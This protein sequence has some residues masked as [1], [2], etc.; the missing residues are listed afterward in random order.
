M[1]VFL[2]ILGLLCC[3]T[4][5]GGHSGSEDIVN[6]L[7]FAAPS[8]LYEHGLGVRL[9]RRQLSVSPDGSTDDVST[10]H[11]HG[12]RL[13][14][15]VTDAVSAT[16]INVERRRYHSV[17]PTAGR[18]SRLR[19]ATLQQACP[20]RRPIYPSPSPPVMS[21][22]P[23]ST[24]SLRPPPAPADV[25]QDNLVF[26]HVGEM[27]FI[28]AL[29]AGDAVSATSA[30]AAA[31]CVML[32]R[33]PVGVAIDGSG[34]GEAETLV[35]VMFLPDAAGLAWAAAIATASGTS[36]E[37][38][39]PLLPGSGLWAPMAAPVPIPGSTVDVR[40]LKIVIPDIG[41]EA[42]TMLASVFIGTFITAV[43]V[44]AV[45]CCVF[46]VRKRQRR[47]RVFDKFVLAPSDPQHYAPGPHAATVYGR[48]WNDVESEAHVG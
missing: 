12:R 36:L 32:L 2:L 6:L 10:L 29:S 18:S 41:E 23:S 20:T 28:S 38:L 16:A 47:E 35:R 21:A 45:G 31:A 9:R 25:P 30:S 8:A 33:D 13:L 26:A 11:G 27:D 24:S 1:F 17:A 19:A 39:G 4:A 34:H 22:A 3:P 37:E 40:G 42:I 46:V 48:F 43:L 44:V 5:V 7:S 15:S 14:P